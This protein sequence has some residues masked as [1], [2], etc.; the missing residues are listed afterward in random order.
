M[1]DE[2]PIEKLLHRYAKKRRADAGAPVELHPASR[3]QLQGE[4]ARQFRNARPGRAPFSF[5]GLG[6]GW[7]P[8]L[9]WGLPLLA[10][11]AVGSWALLVR[12]ATKQL[13]LGTVADQATPYTTDKNLT[14]RERAE[15][16][17]VG[18]P[19]V[20]ANTIPAE[21][22]ATKA[23]LPSPVSAAAPSRN[24]PAARFA[25]HGLE[26]GSR[27]AEPALAF[28]AKGGGRADKSGAVAAT[29]TAV[30]AE[31]AKAIQDSNE[32]KTKALATVAPGSVAPI[33]EASS[34]AT[35]LAYFDHLEHEQV[36]TYSQSFANRAPETPK[37][38]A[39]KVIALPPLSPV[40]ANFRVEQT[41]RQLRVVDSDGSTYTGETDA[42]PEFGGAVGGQKHQTVQ[43]FKRDGKVNQLP[44]TAAMVQS[45]PTQSNFYRVTGTNRTL[46]Q[47]VEF[48]WSFMEPTNA[49]VWA[50]ARQSGAEQNKDAKKLPTQFPVPLQNS[51]INGR[52][53][54][55]SG[56]AIEINAV[57]VSP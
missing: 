4:V 5:T 37:Q 32:S 20:V 45:Q 19:P 47:A 40:L 17:S 50:Q 21:F 36:P 18:T 54:F 31:P 42:A 34:M 29:K 9:A 51:F 52:A 28:G 49:P 8:R 56:E 25:D 6:R 38:K 10:L 2:R 24:R 3:R 12:P 16:R 48:T 26:D 33:G 35:N 23:P 30:L 13:A 7:L 15:V 53:Q 14:K 22:S 57:P 44:A 46:N 55:G 27:R 11:V 41:G 43:L 39:A 1:N